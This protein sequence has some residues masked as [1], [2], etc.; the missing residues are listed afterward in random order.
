M[1]WSKTAFVHNVVHSSHQ[2]RPIGLVISREHFPGMSAGTGLKEGC[3]MFDKIKDIISDITGGKDIGDLDLGGFEKY[4]DGVSWPIG[5]DDLV[6][7]LQNN[8]A[9]DAIVDKV[10]GLDVDSINSPDDL[11]NAVK[12][13]F[14]DTVADTQ[15]QVDA[16]AS[17]ARGQVDAA[18]GDAKAAA[19][20]AKGKLQNKL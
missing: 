8:G 17:D 18:V 13:S 5:K 20:D 3:A 14:A 16:A 12:G 7:A 1:Q 6:T 9:P 4:L 11:V 10:K 19:D 15:G 2:T